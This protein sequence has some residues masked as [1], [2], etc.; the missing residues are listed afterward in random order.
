MAFEGIVRSL[1]RAVLVPLAQASGAA[2]LLGTALRRARALGRWPVRQ[3]LY[4][5]VYFTGL[6]ALPRTSVIGLL[7]GIIVLTQAASLVGKNAALGARILVWAVVRELGPL[8]A[9]IIVIGRSASA[10][11]AELGSMRVHRETDALRA[12]GIDPLRYL[13]V[14]RLVGLTVSLLALAICFQAVT[15]LGGLAVTSLVVR[16]PF[17][18]QTRN[19]TAA[20]GIL[21]LAVCLGKCL[22]F[23]LIIAAS[24]CW[25]GLQVRS[26]ITEVPQATTR[27]VMQSLT[28]VVVADVLLTVVAFA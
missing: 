7:L 11:A 23:G 26:S 2:A 12:M 9:A 17:L 4:R 19:V 8:F 6:Q 15:I 16:L 24:A 28:L 20:L 13:V 27:A 10:I 18:E 25:H 1:G 14:P 5:Q 3:V 21:D 22:L